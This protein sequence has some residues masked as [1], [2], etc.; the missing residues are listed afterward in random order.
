MAF[1]TKISWMVGIV[2][3]ILM[4]VSPAESAVIE[5]DQTGA[6]GGTVSYGGILGTAA[7]GSGIMFNLIEGVGTPFNAG[8][9]LTCNPCTLTFTT[10]PSTSEG[11]TH[12]AWG[13][14]GTFTLSGTIPLSGANPTWPGFTGTILT[15]T[16]DS[17]TADGSAGAP[18]KGFLGF[19]QDI[20]TDELVKFFYGIDP[21]TPPD[22]PIFSFINTEITASG[23]S[24]ITSGPF[25]GA[26]DVSINDA[27]ITNEMPEPGS[28]L[29][30]LLG[31]GGLALSRRRR[32]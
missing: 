19:G 20:K 23:G 14:G 18:P 9:Q 11:P 24:V 21:V 30:I 3:A 27:D 16:F 7:S 2:I 22:P 6:S 13:P 5:I 29:L 26:F 32:S 31:L 12:W 17:M 1:R 28:S 10:G 15:G 25:A 4:V 8:A